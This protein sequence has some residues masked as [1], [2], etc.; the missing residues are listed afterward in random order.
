[1]T[2]IASFLDYLRAELNRS[3][4]TVE[5]YAVALREFEAFFHSLAEGITWESA[6]TEIVREWV[7]YMIDEEDKK[8][9]TVSLALSA[10]RTFYRYLMKTGKAVAN[11]AANVKAPKKAKK[12]PA[13]VKEEN[14]SQLL[15][16][17]TFTDDFEG[18]RDRLIILMLYSTGMR[19]AEI[20][21]LQ[22]KDILWGEKAVKVTG[23]R[24]KQR[25]IPISDEL[26]KEVRRYIDMRTA[27]FSNG[28]EGTAFLL[29]K[30]GKDLRPDEIHR[31]V[32]EKLA[33]VT[34]QQKRSPHV[35]RHSF[36]T[37]MLNHGADLQAIQQLMG[38]ESLETTQIYTHLSF[39]E[40]KNAYNKAHPRS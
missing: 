1:M 35:L 24:M 34:T 11:P 40:L 33:M 6:D 12:L 9:A 25:I 14:M 3:E 28:Y 32:T 4:R 15:D 5:N 10:L 36:A 19:R 23:K 22:D 20:L 16:S 38:H 29:G 30:K 8:P 31:I 21:G 13:F 17:C 39:E 7:V 2:N 26:L 18:R 37:A 27:Y